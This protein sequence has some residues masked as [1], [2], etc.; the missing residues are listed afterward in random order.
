MIE[1]LLIISPACLPNY[2]F[3]AALGKEMAILETRQ[4]YWSRSNCDLKSFDAISS[5]P[6]KLHLCSIV[7]Y[8]D[9]NPGDKTSV[10]IKI[11]M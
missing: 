6:I 7:R 8:G 3:V 10:L 11:K 1:N 2:I 5:L 4:V 9:S